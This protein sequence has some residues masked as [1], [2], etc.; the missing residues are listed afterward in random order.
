MLKLSCQKRHQG[1]AEAFA[2][3]SSTI[4][5][6]LHMPKGSLG[7]KTSGEAIAVYMQEQCCEYRLNHAF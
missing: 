5:Q 4:I 2:L 7:A 3:L 6:Q 1:L